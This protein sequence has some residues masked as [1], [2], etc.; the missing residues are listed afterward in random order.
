MFLRRVF[1]LFS[2]LFL[3]TLPGCIGLD[4]MTVIESIRTT[5][6]SGAYIE[7]VPFFAQ[8]AQMCGPSA[9]ASV[10]NYKNLAYVSPVEIATEV[11]SEKL[12]GTLPPDMLI[13]ARKY[14]FNAELYYGGFEDLKEKLNKGIP[15]IL[16]LN[17][18]L[19]IYPVGHYIVAVGYSDSEAAVIAH[20]GLYKEL[21]YS[22][23]RLEK[24]WSKT[25]YSTMVIAPGSTSNSAD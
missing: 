6:E 15:L 8:D 10:M 13:Y 1:L 22:Y 3:F 7:D 5:P 17:L 12:R 14:G 16:F 23:G 20:S 4:S 9:L 25:G 19:D 11:Y 18:G 21:A 2:C 24:V